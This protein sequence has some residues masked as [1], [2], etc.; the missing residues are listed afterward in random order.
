[1]VSFFIFASGG[2]NALEYSVNDGKIVL[3][4]EQVDAGDETKGYVIKGATL[5]AGVTSINN[6]S[7]PSVYEENGY[8]IVGIKDGENNQTGGVLNALASVVTGNVIL[9][10]N[11]EYIGLC[12]FCDFSNVTQYEL[13]DKLSSV[14]EYAFAYNTSL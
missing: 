5:S 11:I 1:M 2:V 6:W 12:A 3:D 7:M 8:P 14:G 4:L 13:N 10:E 9:G